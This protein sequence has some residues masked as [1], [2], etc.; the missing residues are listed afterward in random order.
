MFYASEKNL[1]MYEQIYS[2][3]NPKEIDISEFGLSL[4]IELSQKIIQMEKVYDKI[5]LIENG[6]ILNE[7]LAE[8]DKLLLD[9][10]KVYEFKL[11]P[12]FESKNLDVEE[13][14]I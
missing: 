8:L 2:S 9:S 12:N 13:V 6:L 14:M 5:K 10:P 7:F 11:N 4:K 1:K 3:E